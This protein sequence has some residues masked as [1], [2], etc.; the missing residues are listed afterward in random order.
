MPRAGRGVRRRRASERARSILENQ[1]L[2]VC[3]MRVSSRLITPDEA[4]D[5]PYLMCLERFCVD[6]VRRCPPV[7]LF[8]FY[9]VNCCKLHTR[10]SFP[11]NGLSLNFMGYQPIPPFL[12]GVEVR[13]D[14]ECLCF[15]YGV[16]RRK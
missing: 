10:H 16:W 14:C 8:V 12:L 3:K 11:G 7:Y 5:T 15:I 2:L 4:W 1:S 13:L 9:R 6:H